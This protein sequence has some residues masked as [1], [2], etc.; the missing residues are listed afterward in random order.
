MLPW[1]DAQYN[2]IIHDCNELH[3]LLTSI[4]KSTRNPKK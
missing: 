4:T 2:S 1:T 3:A